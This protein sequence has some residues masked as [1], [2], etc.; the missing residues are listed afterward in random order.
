MTSVKKTQDIHIEEGCAILYMHQLMSLVIT[1]Q[2]Y[3]LIEIFLET[4][5]RFRCV[6]SVLK[7]VR[8]EALQIHSSSVSLQ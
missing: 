5:Q 6:I 3:V 2:V 7:K 4:R 8:Q 1:S